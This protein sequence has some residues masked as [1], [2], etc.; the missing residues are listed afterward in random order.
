MKK[1][2]NEYFN[3]HDIYPKV[4]LEIW[5][6]SSKVTAWAV[7]LLKKFDTFIKFHFIKKWKPRLIDEDAHPRFKGMGS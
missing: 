5:S 1:V 3:V 4:E 2:V 6:L 7:R